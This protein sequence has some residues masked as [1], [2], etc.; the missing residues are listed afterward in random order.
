MHRDE[1]AHATIDELRVLRFET[2]DF[3]PM[4]K[5]GDELIDAIRD[6]RRKELCFEGHR[7]FDLR[8]YGVNSVRPF[9]KEIYHRS[10]LYSNK[11]VTTE[12]EYVLK[13][14]SQDKAAYVLPIPDDAID[15]NKGNLSNEVRPER[16]LQPLNN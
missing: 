11:T 8:R 14:Y 2:A 12:G 1:E 3:K 15:F 6:E 16:T 5:N 4:D 9:E 10:I 13:P 7:W